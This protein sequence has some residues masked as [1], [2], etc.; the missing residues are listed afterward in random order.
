MKLVEVLDIEDCGSAVIAVVE[1]PKV[2][3]DSYDKRKS[4]TA[5]A[6]IKLSDCSRW[7]NWELFCSYRDN[8]RGYNIEKI[9]KAISILTKARKEM[10]KQQKVY[11][12]K[13]AEVIKHNKTIAKKKVTPTD[14]E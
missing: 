10:V 6:F 8:R 14:I 9:D 3:T 4:I 12:K 1:P 7:I 5:S 13:R 2:N 11:V